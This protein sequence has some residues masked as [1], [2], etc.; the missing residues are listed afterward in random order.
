MI[1]LEPQ[2]YMSRSRFTNIQDIIGGVR[3]GEMKA[4][5]LLY[6]FMEKY[7]SQSVSAYL[8]NNGGYAQDVEDKFQDAFIVLLQAIESE[9]FRLKPVS[10]K[11]YSD[12]LGAYFMRTVQNL[13]KKELRW[14]KRPTIIAE[15]FYEDVGIDI[16]AGIVEEEFG[17]LHADCQAVLSKYFMDGLSTRR[18]GSDLNISTQ[19]VKNRITRC[20]DKLLNNLRFLNDTELSTKIWE[21]VSQGLDD[22]DPKCRQLIQSFYLKGQGLKEIASKLGYSSS[23]SA[24]EQKRKCVKQLNKAIVHN[25]LKT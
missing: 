18:I 3:E 6:L 9:R 14:R 12:Q 1:Y 23:H 16:F 20:V 21:I 8:V 15:D 19:N 10:L 11:S 17:Q 5:Q 25:L 24:T 2:V 13:W 7:H 4:K 22:L